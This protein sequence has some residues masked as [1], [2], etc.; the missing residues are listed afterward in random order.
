MAI[1]PGESVVVEFYS[2]VS[3]RKREIPLSH[4]DIN[5][6]EVSGVHEG[7]DGGGGGLEF[8]NQ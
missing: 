6:L 4:T 2:S 5:P 3:V 7:L 8:S 1:L